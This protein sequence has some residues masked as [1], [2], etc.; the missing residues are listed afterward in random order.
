MSENP[1]LPIPLTALTRPVAALAMLAR[2]DRALAG[3][4]NG[5]ENAQVPVVDELPPAG[6]GGRVL[7]LRDPDTLLVSYW[8]DDGTQWVPF[9]SQPGVEWAAVKSTTTQSVASGTKAYMTFTSFHTSNASVF[10]WDSDHAVTTHEAGLYLMFLTFAASGTESDLHE[11]NAWL[12]AGYPSATPTGFRD[13]SIF[14]TFWSANGPPGTLSTFNGPF[15]VGCI[16]LVVVRSQPD[17]FFNSF[18][19]GYSSQGDLAITLA[20]RMLWVVRLRDGVGDVTDLM[21]E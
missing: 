12:D 14:D 1:K 5:G 19:A 21:D 17:P 10:D 2:R 11:G 18:V 4:H 3:W 6:R 20:D 13:D 7:G 8:G 16:D 9:A 15:D